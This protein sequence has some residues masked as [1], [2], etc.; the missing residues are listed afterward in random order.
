MY[1]PLTVHVTRCKGVTQFGCVMQVSVVSCS[2]CKYQ[3]I[4]HISLPTLP[5]TESCPTLQLRYSVW[6]F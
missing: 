3:D 6:M 5:R 2:I 4:P 1:Q